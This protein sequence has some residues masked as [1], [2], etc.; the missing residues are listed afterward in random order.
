MKPSEKKYPFHSVIERGYACRVNIND[1]NDV[2]I[3]VGFGNRK[4]SETF[5]DSLRG[6][7]K[8]E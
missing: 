3:I 8:Y 4:A 1:E 2:E 6:R 5:C 7:H